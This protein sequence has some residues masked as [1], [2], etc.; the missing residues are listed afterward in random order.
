MRINTYLS[1]PENVRTNQHQPSKYMHKRVHTYLPAPE[2]PGTN[3][4]QPA[5]IPARCIKCVC[6]CMCDC[7]SSRTCIYAFL[8]ILTYDCLCGHDAHQLQVSAWNMPV[9]LLTSM[10]VRLWMCIQTITCK[11]YQTFYIAWIHV[12]VLQ[13]SPWMCLL[14]CVFVYVCTHNICMNV[15][16]IYAWIYVWMHLSKHIRIYTQN[17]VTM[18]TKHSTP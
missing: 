15:H 7:V 14:C 17:H 10:H 6:L 13:R 8:S 9:Y 2:N 16:T 11:V 3:Q 12:G 1:C 5:Q 4:H 18:Y